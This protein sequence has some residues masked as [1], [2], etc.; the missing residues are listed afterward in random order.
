MH[1]GGGE[2]TTAGVPPPQQEHAGDRRGD[3]GHGRHEHQRRAA[4]HRTDGGVLR[5]R[6]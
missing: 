2:H 4:E 5:Q 6:E 3:H 1:Q